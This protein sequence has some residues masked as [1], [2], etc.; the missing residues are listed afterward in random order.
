MIFAFLSLCCCFLLIF[1]VRTAISAGSKFIRNHK[2]EAQKEADSKPKKKS[3]D[4]VTLQELVL[5]T[6]KPSSTD[7]PVTIT[8]SSMG[9]CTLGTDANKRAGLFLSECPFRPGI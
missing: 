5:N 8:V 4:N 6:D 2:A 1:G 9:D 7:K 3:Y